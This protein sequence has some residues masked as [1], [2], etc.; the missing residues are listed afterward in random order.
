MCLS[1]CEVG[2]LASVEGNLLTVQI[3]LI[4]KMQDDSTIVPPPVKKFKKSPA[5][6]QPLTKAPGEEENELNATL[7]Q[8]EKPTETIEETP[9]SAEEEPASK[10]TPEETKE[11][12]TPKP[13][14]GEAPKSDEPTAEETAETTEETPKSTEE[15][16]ETIETTVIQTEGGTRVETTTVIITE[17]VTMVTQNGET[18]TTSTT[19][20]SYDVHQKARQEKYQGAPDDVKRYQI[21]DEDVPWMTDLPTYAPVT[22]TDAKIL[23]EKPVWADPDVADEAFDKIAFNAMDG[24][25]NR[26]S[27]H[28]DYV[29]EDLSGKQVP[30][31]P[32]G[33][34]GMRGRGLLG[35]W[36]PNHAADPIVTRFKRDSEG[37]VE[38]R[39]DKPVLE[40]VAIQRRDTKEWAI[41]GGMVDGGEHVSATLKREFG[42]E[43]LNSLE[44][45]QK[46][47][48][49]TLIADFFKGGEKIYEGYVDDPR[50]TDNAWM[51]SCAY[52]YHDDDGKKAGKIPL[53]AGDDAQAVRWM[54]IDGDIQLYASHKDFIE[55][56]CT[57]LGAHF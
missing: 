51:E 17:E 49:K 20:T 18:I 5:E 29:F 38:K 9:K 36:G 1:Y 10:E 44:D 2:E 15:T 27:Y 6:E 40:F 55:K 35:K 11:E 47:E 46:E 7:P 16:T 4:R 8:E 23:T 56:V 12:D 19:T 54:T 30:R 13:A 52:N 53:N 33:R 42:E 26:T 57:R 37:N 14:N 24:Q 21:K 22:Y 28:G 43:A 39:G 32:M 45:D 50:N 34:T 25:T 3:C 41:P 31:N 48:T